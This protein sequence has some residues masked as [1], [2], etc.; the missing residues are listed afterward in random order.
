MFEFFAFFSRFE[1]A[2]KRAGFLK[3]GDKAEPCWDRFANSVRNRLFTKADSEFQAGR[4]YLMRK[5]PDTQVVVNGGLGWRST[6]KGDGESDEQYLLR[7]VRI[8][9]NNLFHGGKYPYPLCSVPDSAATDSYSSPR[10]LCL[11]NL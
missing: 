7:L 1:Y 2:L 6:P 5:P 10:S 3:N 11:N 9:R 8:V 4:E